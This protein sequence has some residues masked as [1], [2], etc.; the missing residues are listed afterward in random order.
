M[1]CFE[2]WVNGERLY[3]AGIGDFGGLSA[4]LNWFQFRP[5]EYLAEQKTK[6]LPRLIIWGE[7]DHKSFAWPE[8]RLKIGDEVTIR[9]VEG[10]VPDKPAKTRNRE[11]DPTS[12]GTIQ[13][14]RKALRKFYKDLKRMLDEEMEDKSKGWRTNLSRKVAIFGYRV[15][16]ARFAVN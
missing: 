4:T 15:L 6:E 12:S 3:T 7:A 16:D 5:E 1:V 8:P 2:I 13:Q 11:P 14:R 10:A 9:I